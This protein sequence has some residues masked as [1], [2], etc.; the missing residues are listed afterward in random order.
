MF[1]KR[2]EWRIKDYVEWAISQPVESSVSSTDFTLSQGQSR[3]P[4]VFKLIVHPNGSDYV[5]IFLA[6]EGEE[7]AT[8]LDGYFYLEKRDGSHQIKPF[9]RGPITIKSKANIGWSKAFTKSLIKDNVNK[10]LPLGALTIGVSVTVNAHVSENSST[11]EHEISTKSMASLF[12]EH[13]DTTIPENKGNY[14]SFSD[15]QITCRN[16]VKPGRDEKIVFKCH[17][18]MLSTG[19]PVFHAMFLHD[20]TEN[21]TNNVD[22]CDFSPEAV[23][24]MLHFFY[25]GSVNEEM[26]NIELLAA[27]DKYQIDRLK[28]LCEETLA[29]KLR[30]ENVI[31]ALFAANLHGTPTFQ[32]KAKH[33]A[34]FNWAAIP[35]NA[36]FESIKQF[37]ALLVNILDIKAGLTDM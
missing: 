26:I 18:I 7:D 27:A 3:I 2:F 16:E 22:I 33:F 12:K 30:A 35:R 13:F 23:R 6:N 1:T 37:P 5:S 19:S 4:Y 17:K 34:A 15:F 36:T 20:T 25:T 8:V 21:H 32:Q 11:Q 28:E 10:Y 24:S 9:S 31:I 29:T 14:E